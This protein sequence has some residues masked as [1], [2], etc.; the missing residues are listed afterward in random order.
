M[1]L[2]VRMMIMV[3]VEG[4]V[5]AM[6]VVMDV[7]VAVGVEVVQEVVTHFQCAVAEHG[8]GVYDQYQGASAGH[9]AKVGKWV[10]Y[11]RKEVAGWQPLLG[12]G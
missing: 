7:N 2:V 8:H 4:V 1:H 9:T 5:V 3:I 10:G 11:K 12:I 6:I